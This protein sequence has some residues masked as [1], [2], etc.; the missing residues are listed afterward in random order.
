MFPLA[1]LPYKNI[2][3]LVAIL[4][5]LGG[6]Y[7]KG[8]HD[9]SVS[10]K[11][12]W[13]LAN[14]VATQAALAAE[15]DA[16]KKENAGIE[17]ASNIQSHATQSLKGVYDYYQKHPNIVYRPAAD[18]LCHDTYPTTSNPVPETPSNPGDHQAT[19]PDTGHPPTQ[20]IEPNLVERCAVTTVQMQA[21]QEY[22]TGLESVFR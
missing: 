11:K 1:L 7:W 17:L 20:I 3:A 12:E 4:C 22:V 6:I 2:I 10:V 14:A 16:R 18:G 8:H 21:C 5:V 9:G 13:D 19:N 15:Q